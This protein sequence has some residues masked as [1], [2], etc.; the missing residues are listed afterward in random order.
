MIEQSDQMQ[1][2]HQLFEGLC[3]KKCD[4]YIIWADIG[5]MANKTHNTTLDQCLVWLP[6]SQND[7]PCRLS[8]KWPQ[9]YNCNR[10]HRTSGYRLQQHSVSLIIWDN[11]Q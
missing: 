4:K 1:Q 3:N 10:N 11:E 5:C 7:R 2:N 9:E 8:L 6:T